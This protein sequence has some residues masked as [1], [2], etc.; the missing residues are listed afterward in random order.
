MKHFLKY[1]K[2]NLYFV[3]SLLM[4]TASM[5]VAVFILIE[6]DLGRRVDQTTVGFIYLGSYESSEYDNI[7]DQRVTQWQAQADFKISYQQYEYPIDISLYELDLEE[8]ID[9]I[10][11]D[12]NNK[13][14][15]NI[16]ESNQQLIASGIETHFTS[17][18]IDGF[19]HERFMTD[20]NSEMQ[21]LINRKVFYLVDYLD[22]SLASYEIG[23]YQLTGL[24]PLLVNEVT[25]VESFTIL[26]NARFSLLN[27]LGET[28]LENEALSL[29]ASL[30]QEVTRDSH[31]EG[32]IFD[33]FT[34]LPSWA[35]PGVNARILKVNGYDFT[36]Y[37]RFDL[38]YTVEIE[39]IN[40]TTVSLSLIG[41]PYRSSYASTSEVEIIVAFQTIYVEN[42]TLTDT[43]PG[44]VVTE[45]DTEFIYELEVT[46]GVD[47]EVIFYYRTIT[48]LGGVPQTVKLYDEAFLP[49]SRI[50]EQHIVPKEGA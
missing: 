5:G 32:F 3:I 20:L 17:L 46:P 23:S 18:L 43:T 24:D 45:N 50:I 16:S 41:Y 8:T 37:N 26:K 47:G 1:L 28:S 36:F 13:A 44:V 15:F 21:T 6:F 11:L 9:R 22:V 10:K 48:P 2:T 19:D 42:L 12:Q 27:T 35:T 29:I 14:Y 49:Q 31:F 7:L 4:L 38:D 25:E 34:V 39:K 33:P 40:D 30:L